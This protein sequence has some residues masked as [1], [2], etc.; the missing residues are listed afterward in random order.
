MTKKQVRKTLLN[1][2]FFDSNLQYTP[3]SLE[4]LETLKVKL[5]DP[6]YRI[7]NK[8]ERLLRNFEKET[9][10]AQKLFTVWSIS[11]Q[12]T[13]LDIKDNPKQL[14]TR[15]QII[16]IITSESNQDKEIVTVGEL[17]FYTMS[18]KDYKIYSEIM[19]ETLVK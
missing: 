14:T 8:E 13:S 16:T 3:D 10:V 17:Q 19:K 1:F 18:K 7:T 4:I 11:T 5:E 2:K 12:P 6:E 9:I 15:Q